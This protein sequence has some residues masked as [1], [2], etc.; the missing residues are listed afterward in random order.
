M[1]TRID[2][3]KRI[4]CSIWKGIIFMGENE[5]L[6]NLPLDSA[7]SENID[8]V[9]T[10]SDIIGEKPEA[11][12]KTEDN[13]EE[14]QLPPPAAGMKEIRL[15]DVDSSKVKYIDNPLPVPKRRE[16]REMD[17]LISVS[18]DDDFDIKDMTG[19]DF[20]DIV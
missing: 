1:Q 19:M 5:H 6:D 11:E 10:I 2:Y 15:E 7:D 16:H 14:K 12:E 4:V 3:W 9:I 17:Y 8:K 18:D 13:K 20:Y